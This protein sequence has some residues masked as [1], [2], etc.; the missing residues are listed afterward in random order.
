MSQIIAHVGGVQLA[1]L[2]LVP[3][4]V[5]AALYLRRCATLADT[6]RAVPGWRQACFLGGLAL[7]AV[8]LTSPLG[9][10]A[11]ELFV[12]HMAEHLLMADV[13]ALLLVVGL[14]GPLLAPVLRIGAF[15]RL[16]VLTHPVVAITL[17][18]VNIT[19]WH[20]PLFHEAAVRSEVV[21][22]V[23]HLCFVSFGAAVWMP[24]FG[25]LPKPTWFTNGAAL[26]YILGVR[27]VGAVLANAF[28]FGGGAFYDVYRPE[29]FDLS[30]SSDQIAA[31]TVMM[32]EESI[33]TICLFAWLFLRAAREGD[34][35]Q[36]LL[37]LAA[38]RGVKLDPARA[39]RAVAAGR[40]GDLRER[41]EHAADPPVP[42]ARPGQ[43]LTWT[44]NS[45]S[46]CG[47]VA[48]GVVWWMVWTPISRGGFRLN[49]RSST[50][51]TSVAGRPSRSSASS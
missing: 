41:I 3:Q 8:A 14:T 24:L 12:A 20:I 2:Q 17:W 21:H 4:V 7:I 43:A 28:L 11:D 35:Q 45:S 29:L 19:F 30:P 6:P 16:R 23:Q 1:P 37:D 40:G 44:P 13:A 42:E 22:A 25:P 51:T 33:L 31:G 47:I 50:N 46:S 36:E 26:V 38:A 15:D 32:I 18:A 49:G 34:E 9:H 27:L 10:M 5:V 48:C 39:R